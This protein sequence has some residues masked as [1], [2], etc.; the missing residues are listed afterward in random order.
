M[1]WLPM[2]ITLFLFTKTNAQIGIENAEEFAKIKQATLYV[3]LGDSATPH[4]K[5]M[6]NAIR[7]AWKASKIE[8]VSLANDPSLLK[9]G[10]LYA[11]VEHNQ[12]S[13]KFIRETENRGTGITTISRSASVNND[14]FFIHFWLLKDNYNPEKDLADKHQKTI[15]RAELYLKSIGSGRIEYSNLNFGSLAFQGDFCNGLP[16]HIKSIFAEVSNSIDNNVT[17]DLK[18][19]MKPKTELSKLKKDTL[20]MA[21]FW[22]GPGGTMLPDEV[23]NSANGKYINGLIESYGHPIKLIRRDE[24]SRKILEA[25]K[26]VYYLNYVQSSA[27]KMMGI[28]NGLTGE[29]IYYFFNDKSYRLKDKD[30]K[31]ISDAVDEAN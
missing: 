6:M 4:G 1:K 12:N 5:E 22:Y 19:D 8:F 25:K 30:F 29:T 2:L 21:N 24:L 26:P 14:Y 20:F 16:G 23:E 15:A 13:F 7:S 17:R 28:V 10:N 27:D 18:K 3:Q 31:K 9:P 11:N